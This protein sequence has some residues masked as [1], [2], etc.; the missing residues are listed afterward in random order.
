MSGDFA[1]RQ[2]GGGR[3]TVV[4]ALANALLGDR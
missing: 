3:L 1:L 2:S 4:R